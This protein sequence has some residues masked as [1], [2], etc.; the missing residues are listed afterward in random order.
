MFE[1]DSQWNGQWGQEPTPEPEAPATPE[2]EPTPT[3][4][5][6]KPKT[7]KTK[8][9]GHMSAAQ[10]REVLDARE[11]VDKARTALVA[12]TGKDDDA[13]LTCALL[14]GRTAAPARLLADAAGESNESARAIM[15]VSAGQKDR[16]ALRDAARLASAL[17]PD[18]KD[19]LN[20]TN[21]MD[22]AR[23]LSETAGLLDRDLLEVLA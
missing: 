23:T 8:T 18:L 11:R 17:N 10:V 13:E 14:D 15:L 4:K 12:L 20:T 9:K 21:M 2:P 1:N 19:R 22:L 5:A 7:R 6:P 16:N 3:S